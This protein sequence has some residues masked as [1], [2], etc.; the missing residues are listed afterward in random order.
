[1]ELWRIFKTQTTKPRV[2]GDWRQEAMGVVI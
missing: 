1:M 2:K